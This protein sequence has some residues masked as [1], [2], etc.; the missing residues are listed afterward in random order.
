MTERSEREALNNCEPVLTHA[1]IRKAIFRIAREIDSRH[2][3]QE[4]EF[5]VVLK[6]ALP[7]F[8]FLLVELVD[9][10]V[11][12]N[13]HFVRELRGGRD[14]CFLFSPATVLEGKIVIIVE[15]IVDEGLTLKHLLK[16]ICGVCKPAS[17]E[18]AALVSRQ[19]NH[20]LKLDYTGFT[21]PA[22]YLYGF[23]L[24]INERFR[25]LC[26]IYVSK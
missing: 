19:D 10:G 15:D 6:G 1:Q 16:S 13:Y 12:Y 7:F 20:D 4:V 3:G 18:I 8:A 17:I 2:N 26:N 9:C 14:E 24:D 11:G 5:V 23:G 25:D 21:L 22:G